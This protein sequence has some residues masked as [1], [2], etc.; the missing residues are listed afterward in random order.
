VA[1]TIEGATLSLDAKAGALTESPTLGAI[2]VGTLN[3]TAATGI[4][5][6]S[7]K[8]AITTLGVDDPGSGPN[9]ITR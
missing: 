9:K 5:L 3:A 2:E 7:T 1:G 8:N 6:T 4:T